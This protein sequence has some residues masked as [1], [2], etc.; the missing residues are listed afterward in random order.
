MFNGIAARDHGEI[1]EE[2]GKKTKEKER[3]RKGGRDKEGEKDRK[4]K[5][6]KVHI[7]VLAR[8]RSQAQYNQLHQ[9]QRYPQ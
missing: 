5:E 4:H 6:E 3:G 2:E 7:C 8:M 9:E 1:E